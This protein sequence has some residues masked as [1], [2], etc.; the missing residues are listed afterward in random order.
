[1]KRTLLGLL[2]LLS[3]N[4]VF[5]QR[6]IVEDEVDTAEGANI[7]M[8]P[9]SEAVMPD[10]FVPAED[11]ELEE[12]EVTWAEKAGKAIDEVFAPIVGVLG[13][14]MFW[15]PFDAIGLYDP[16]VYHEDG[17]PVIK[18]EYIGTVSTVEGE[19][20]VEGNETAFTRQIGERVVIGREEY[21]VETIISDEVLVLK[22]PARR[23]VTEAP[24]RNPENVF[25]GR[26]ATTAGE[27]RVIGTDTRFRKEVGRRIVISDKVYDVDAIPSDNELVLAV[28]AGETIPEAV[29][30]Q[31]NEAPIPFVVVWLVLG[32][33]FFTVFLGFLQFRK[34]SHALALVR[35]VYDDPNEP[36]EVSHFQALTT[37][38]SA[39]VGLGNIA[40][41]AVAIS[42]GG[43]GATFW[44]IIAG[45]LG[46]ATKFAE[47]TLGVK[48]RLIDKDGTVF[49]GPMYY[50]KNGLAK[51]GKGMAKLGAVLAVVFSVLCILGSFGGGNMF[52]VNQAFQQ[53]NGWMAQNDIGLQFEGLWFGIIFAIFVGLVIIGGIKSIARVTDKIV[54]FMCGIYVL[55]ALIILILNYDQVPESF[56]LIIEKAF[57]PRAA[58]GGFMGVLIQ[59]FR[60]AAFSNE[61]G[62]GSASIAHSAAKTDEPVSE[63][64]V[65][66]LEPFVDTVVVCT[67]TALVLVI[68]GEY[69][70]TDTLEGARMT[71]R[72][73]GTE[74]SIF[75]LILTISILL[76]AFSTMISWSY[77]G[78]RAWAYLFGRSKGSI[79]TYKFVFLVFVVIGASIPLGAVIDFSDM[80][81]LGM[82]FPNVLGL[83]LLSREVKRESNDYFARIKSGEIKRYK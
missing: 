71:S 65:A 11:V 61:A 73:F 50:L 12:V 37:A 28:P 6:V 42:L 58:F 40:G 47:C 14:W 29:L 67:M 62:V 83:F 7:E 52:Q 36:G 1:M 39:T 22:E 80:M 57:D 17:T 46:M 64:T 33:I 24:I 51:R 19:R 8:A 30:L 49:G 77:Y 9:D 3:L 27:T 15:D 5:A 69:A 70:T 34:F 41:V 56:A 54:P 59:G 72:A 75:P 81:I 53:M 18:G 2:I 23:T 44:L 78:E 74:I 38:L 48:Y 55:A 63:G 60:R 43:P 31:P 32:A 4:P 25:S 26:I 66:L 68:T 82:A 21:A 76:F 13:E 35:G 45:F 20:R 79:Y 16:V 10:K